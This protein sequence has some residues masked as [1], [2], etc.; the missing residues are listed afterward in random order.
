MEFGSKYVFVEPVDGEIAADGR[1]SD[2]PPVIE[3]V[4]RTW[5]PQPSPLRSARYDSY[6]NVCSYCLGQAQSIQLKRSLL[7]ITA[8]QKK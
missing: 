1:S 2:P 5:N 6:L 7:L 8:A 4:R 3:R